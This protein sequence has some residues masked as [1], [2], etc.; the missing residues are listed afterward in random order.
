MIPISLIIVAA[1]VVLLTRG[2]S[3]GL[4]TGLFVFC[5]LALALFL[6]ASL[7]SIVLGVVVRGLLAFGWFWLLNRLEGSAL[8]WLALVFGLLL[9]L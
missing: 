4:V 5:K 3:V 9:L 6:G 2:G 1:C 7:L 8:W